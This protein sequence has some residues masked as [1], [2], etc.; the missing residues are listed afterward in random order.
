[1]LSSCR[2]VQGNVAKFMLQCLCGVRRVIFLCYRQCAT[3]GTV[4]SFCTFNSLIMTQLSI[5]IVLSISLHHKYE[6]QVWQRRRTTFFT[7]E[8]ALT[9]WKH[10]NKLFTRGHQQPRPRGSSEVCHSHGSGSQGRQRSNRARSPQPIRPNPSRVQV[11]VCTQKLFVLIYVLHIL[12]KHLFQQVAWL[13]F[14]L[15]Q[16][17]ADFLKLQL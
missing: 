5:L 7:L 3:Y 13:L 12:S 17:V 14:Q 1:M 11:I 16:L 2:W 6:G 10:I 4:H 9:T 8:D 15:L